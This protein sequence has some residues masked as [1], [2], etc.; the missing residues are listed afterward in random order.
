MP[1]AEL[2][3]R[4]AATCRRLAFAHSGEEWTIRLISLAYEYEAK[5]ADIEIGSRP[6]PDPSPSPDDPPGGG[7]SEYVQG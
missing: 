4:H 1:S 5:A 3:R 7:S 6:M 2:Y